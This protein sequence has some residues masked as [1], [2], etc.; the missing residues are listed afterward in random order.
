MQATGCCEDRS[1]IGSVALPFY[2]PEHGPSKIVPQAP[3]RGELGVWLF[4]LSASFDRYYADHPEHGRNVDAVFCALVDFDAAGR[5]WR[6]AASTAATDGHLALAA[7][8]ARREAEHRRRSARLR[9]DPFV[10]A[11]LARR[12]GER[13]HAEEKV[14]IHAAARGFRHPDLRVCEQCALVFRA[15]RAR[16]CP[17]C[18]HNPVRITLHPLIAG[19]WHVGY[20]VGTPWASEHFDRAVYYTS[21]CQACDARFQTTRPNGRHCLNC[22]GPS[23]RVRRHRA[24]SRTGRQCFRFAHAEGAKEWSISFRALD[25]AD[26]YLQA[27]NGVIDTDDAETA[28]ALERMVTVR[29]VVEPA[30]P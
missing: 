5:D 6:S 1:R 17:D 13:L 23:G 20:R 25:G 27:V 8:R 9:I 7:G 4:G 19:G 16:R 29:R 26:I 24:G 22:R 2:S 30:R 28:H 14:W 15:P 21:V 11:G 10:R 12:E 3:L 18:R